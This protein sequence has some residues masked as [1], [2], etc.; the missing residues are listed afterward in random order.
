LGRRDAANV[1]K[2][3]TMLKAT[4]N[5][6]LDSAPLGFATALR[7][8]WGS[9]YSKRRQNPGISRRLKTPYN[10][11]QSHPTEIPITATEI[12]TAVVLSSKCYTSH[13][14]YTSSVVA[15][16]AQIQI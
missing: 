5:C 10:K 11:D 16:N 1:E 14:F 6:L 4:R 12:F 15:C 2:I 8:P 7:S 13:A 3:S 9:D